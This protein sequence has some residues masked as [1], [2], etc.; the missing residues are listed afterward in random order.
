MTECE[1][2][3]KYKILYDKFDDVE[4]LEWD[5][6]EYLLD[7]KEKLQD[8][9]THLKRNQ[10]DLYPVS[11]YEIYLHQYEE[12]A[13]KI[14]RNDISLSLNLDPENSLRVNSKLIKLLAADLLRPAKENV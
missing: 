14:I 9:L 13:V 4:M 10:T 8:K 7:N 3:A 1:A 12:E 11:L 2:F 5:I 6:G